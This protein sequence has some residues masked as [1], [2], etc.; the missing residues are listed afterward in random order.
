MPQRVLESHSLHNQAVT[1]H[2]NLANSHFLLYRTIWCWPHRGGTSA[3]PPLRVGCGALPLRRRPEGR[4]RAAA[5]EAARNPAARCRRGFSL[6]ATVGVAEPPWWRPR[7][8]L[9]LIVVVGRSSWGEAGEREGGAGVWRG[10]WM[11][12][13]GKVG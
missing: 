4:C 9:P 2:P 3:P 5:V 1:V 13:V 12:G 10:W 8:A 6:L 11:L 7:E